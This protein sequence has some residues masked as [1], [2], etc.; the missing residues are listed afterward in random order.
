MSDGTSPRMTSQR[1]YLLRAIYAWIVDND[2]TPYLVV[3]ATRPGV[4]VPPGAIQDGKVVL[5]IAGRAVTALDMGNA[6][7]T[8]TARFQGVS[9]SVR[10]PV[11]AVLMIYARETG[12]GMGL[13][14]EPHVPGA[15]DDDGE[16][17]PDGGDDAPPPKRGSHLRIVK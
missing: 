5:N 16:A 9:Q 17:G 2:M 1:P 11:D 15:G 14:E 12:Q 7:I 10:V 4:G 3:D 6:L 8:F 13:A